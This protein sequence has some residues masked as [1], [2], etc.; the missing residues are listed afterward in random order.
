M[1]GI[2]KLTLQL[3]EEFLKACL[4]EHVY[5]SKIATALAAYGQDNPNQVFFLAKNGAESAALYLS[6]DVLL[7]ASAED[8]FMDSLFYFIA[9]YQPKEIDCRWHLCEKLQKRLGGRTESSFFM[10]YK[11]DLPPPVNKTGICPTKD[12]HTVFSVLQQSHEYYRVHLTFESWSAE[13]ARKLSMGLMELVLFYEKGIAVGCGSIVSEDEKAAA[14]A[15]VAVIPSAR[16]KGYGRQISSFLT[17]RIC[18]KGKLPVLISGY[19]EVAEL[20]Q[21]IGYTKCGRW[22]E[23]YL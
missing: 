18:E 11:K 22:G 9:T 4:Q 16:H 12:L 17:A 1:Q 10:E 19:D 2:F 3:K 14:I 23:L 13:L 7:I 5:G 6:G 20:Y 21:T 8:F 15:A